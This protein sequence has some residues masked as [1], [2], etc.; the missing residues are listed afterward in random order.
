MH[1]DI[2]VSVALNLVLLVMIIMIG[3]G[4]YH[5]RSQLKN[6]SERESDSCYSIHCPLDDPRAAPCFGFAIRK[7]TNA[8][9]KI[10]RFFCSN[11]PLIAVDSA[12]KPIK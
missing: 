4:I 3:V 6:C 8:K 1:L 9:D 11:N 2:A 7:V 12:G 10:D 5:Y